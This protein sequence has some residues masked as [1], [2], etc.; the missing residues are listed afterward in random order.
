MHRCW[1]TCESSG[2]RE[3]SGSFGKCLKMIIFFVYLNFFMPTSIEKF[4]PLMS[5]F[6]FLEKINSFRFDSILSTAVTRDIDQSPGL[7]EA[8]CFVALM[9]RGSF[10]STLNFALKWGMAMMQP[11]VARASWR[12]WINQRRLIIPAIDY[13]RSQSTWMNR[14]TSVN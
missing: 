10:K 3:P 5:F 1:S 8:T 6:F 4:F 2:T 13:C 9:C 7:V 11:C 14:I 12:S